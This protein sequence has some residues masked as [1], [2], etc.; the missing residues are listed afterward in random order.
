MGRHNGNSTYKLWINLPR[1][2]TTNKNW[3]CLMQLTLLSLVQHLCLKSETNT[4]ERV[5]SLETGVDE[6]LSTT[7]F[8]DSY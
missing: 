5:S 1:M 4:C 7:L 2:N 3:E 8:Y 6:L